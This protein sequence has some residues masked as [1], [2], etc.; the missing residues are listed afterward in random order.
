MNA[1]APSILVVDD[2]VDTCRNL[3]DIFTDLG[4][5][6]DTAY[7]GEA[8]LELVRKRRYD[9]ALLDLMMPGMDGAT[10]YREIK[11]LR[12]GTVALIVTAHPGDARAEDGLGAG[13]WRLLPK[14]VDF[15]RLMGLIEEALG[16]PL[17]LVVDD[18]AD[19][20]ANLWDLLRE[21]G[22]RVC[23]AH[24]AVTA[25]H[26]INDAE[27]KVILLDM[28]L[29]DGDG[30]QVF[31]AARASDSAAQVIVITGVGADGEQKVQQV[32]SAGARAVLRKPFDVPG[33]LALVRQL[34]GNDPPGGRLPI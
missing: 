15:P 7:D 5:V 6:V 11:K 4:Y 32:M 1:A 20:C 22:Y 23:M 19:L 13:V 8:A 31:Q 12:A 18:D 3:A 14:P 21:R 10:L 16:Q 25:V 17:V 2:E 34:G 27:Y 9:V 33:L 26:R 28:K 24:D 29:P 30:S